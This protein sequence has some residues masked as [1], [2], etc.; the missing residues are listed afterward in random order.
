M[1]SNDQYFS[2]VIPY[3]LQFNFLEKLVDSIHKYADMPF[4]IIVH[5][6]GASGAFAD[7]NL[8]S[9]KVKD[10]VSAIALNMG[11]NFGIATASN[12]AIKLATS[13]YILFLNQ[14]MEMIAPCLR[15]YA[16]VLDKP[17]VGILSPYGDGYPMET[18]EYIVANGTKFSLCHGI[19]SG[20]SLA[21]RK[22]VWED[23][24]GFEQDVISG[25]GDTP[26][27]YNMWRQGYFRAVA[28]GKQR[29]NNPGLEIYKNKY[30]VIGVTGTDCG[31]SKIFP[32]TIEQ[33]KKHAKDREQVCQRN[34]DRVRNEPASI[35][36]IDYW[37]EYSGK[38]IQEDG[39]ISS[40]N[41]EN[42]KRH[43]QDKW[44]NL[45]EKEEVK[46]G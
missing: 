9:L 12:R 34:V 38:I 13:K 3:F 1:I 43:G 5:D 4:E 27:I 42:A 36:N 30:S 26:F 15:D 14:D 18:R 24:G 41:W 11:V 2:I 37:D 6:D 25:C 23:I 20:A 44:R 16:N 10:K 28:L 40:I 39:V 7:D 31:Y 46:S 29:I 17:Y 21:F 8:S 22:D 35:S 19:A 33:L 32:N 45:I